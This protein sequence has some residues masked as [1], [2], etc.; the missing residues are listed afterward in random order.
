MDSEN[1]IRQ[2]CLLN[3]YF[4]GYFTASISFSTS[5]GRC[6]ASVNGVL[7]SSIFKKEAKGY[8][9]R[10]TYQLLNDCGKTIR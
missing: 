4:S 6:K 8:K 10:H 9:K 3:V 1:P 5:K 7:E 2:T